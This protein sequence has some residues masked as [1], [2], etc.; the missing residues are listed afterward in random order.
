L[1]GIVL[2]GAVCWVFFLSSWW[3]GLPLGLALFIYSFTY[4]AHARFAWSKH[5][6]GGLIHRHNELV[7]RLFGFSAIAVQ[8]GRLFAEVVGF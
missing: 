1:F 5:P 7:F 4:D 8:A 2:F 6:D 3:I